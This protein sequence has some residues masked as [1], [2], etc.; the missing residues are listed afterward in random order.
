MS[1]EVSPVVV[2]A[3][4]AVVRKEKPVRPRRRRLFQHRDPKGRFS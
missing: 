3:V 2:A 1:A 4:A